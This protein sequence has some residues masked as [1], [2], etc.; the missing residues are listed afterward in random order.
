MTSL[1]PQDTLFG[2]VPVDLWAALWTGTAAGKYFEEVRA[3][4]ARGDKEEASRVLSAITLTRGIDIR[5]H[6]QAWHFLRELGHKPPPHGEKEVLGVVLEVA[7]PAGLEVVAVYSDKTARYHNYSGASVAWERPDS[8]MDGSID[9]VLDAG[10]MILPTIGIWQ[11]AR[12]LT[13]AKGDARVTILTPSGLGFGEGPFDALRKDPI[14]K[15]VMG[16][17]TNLIV[18]LAK[19]GTQFLKNRP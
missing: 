8:S 16:P 3:W 4:L 10:R 7:L 19:A 5:H 12:R 1:R 13:L 18:K 6:L 17:A 9:A 11:G 15:L 14:G 2:D